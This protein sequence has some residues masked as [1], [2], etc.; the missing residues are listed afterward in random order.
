MAVTPRVA[1]STHEVL[2]QPPPLQDHNAF[3]ADP[4]LI[5]ALERDGGAWGVDRVRLRRWG[6]V[7][8]RHRGR[9][10]FGSR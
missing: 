4:A 6:V 3:D 7:R 1:D 8:R 10:P 5:E 9:P 2:N